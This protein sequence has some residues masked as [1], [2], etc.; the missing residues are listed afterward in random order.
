MIIAYAPTDTVAVIRF[1]A[2]VDARRG[3]LI[4]RDVDVCVVAI[5]GMPM[6]R[7]EIERRGG[8]DRNCER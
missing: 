1:T 4:D 3:R 6:R 7:A 2:L 8:R 5:D